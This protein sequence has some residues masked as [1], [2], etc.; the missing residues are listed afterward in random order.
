MIPTDMQDRKIVRLGNGD[1]P[2]KVISGDTIPLAMADPGRVRVGH[3]DSPSR[4]ALGDAR[5][6]NR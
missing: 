6:I 2:A 5:P 3:V 1:S 4:V